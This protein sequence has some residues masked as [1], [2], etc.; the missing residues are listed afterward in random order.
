MTFDEY[1]CHP[2]YFDKRPVRNGS[3]KMM[4]GDNIYRRSEIDGTWE[5][6][7]SHHS[8]P[9]G[10]LDTHNVRRDTSA[11]RV[12]VSRHF[13]YFGRNAPA[14]PSECLTSIG[15]RNARKHRVFTA[16]RCTALISWIEREHG[17]CLGLVS[18]RPFQFERS[19]ARYSAKADAILG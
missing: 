5:Q 15:Y 17:R 18:G 14:V 9:D 3:R 11:D 8:R 4:V 7:D 13:F 6:A 12:L 19:G 10:S 16:D 2:D 1:W